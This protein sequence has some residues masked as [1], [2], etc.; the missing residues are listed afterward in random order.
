MNL[1][2]FVVL[3]YYHPSKENNRILPCMDC[4]SVNVMV[5]RT[6]GAHWSIFISLKMEN[7]YFWYTF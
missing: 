2:D 5:L 4:L 3:I 6:Y 1:L 7:F